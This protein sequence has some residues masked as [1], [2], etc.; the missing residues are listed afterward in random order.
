TGPHPRQRAPHPHGVYFIGSE[1]WIPDLGGDCIHRH[2]PGDGRP[3]GRIDV[4]PGAGPRHLTAAGD[5]LI[6]ELDNTVQAIDGDRP[7]R[8]RVSTL[9][10][11]SRT[12]SIAAEI[13]S[14][15][16]C[17]YVSNRGHDSIAVLTTSPELAVV[18]HVPSGGR[19]PRHFLVTPDGGHLIVA[20]RDSHNLVA[21]ALDIQ[22][23]LVEPV[24][25]V[26]CPSPVHLLA[27]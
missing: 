14:H 25:E 23:R 13:Q 2:D 5:Y 18:Q 17:L 10:E 9:P 11:A 6:N 12:P 20:N 19:H 26:A 1:L 7:G 8:A 4:S 16:G 21:I 15:R 22:G 3:L 24:A 27:Y